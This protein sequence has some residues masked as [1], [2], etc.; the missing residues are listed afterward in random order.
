M[1]EHAFLPPS[2]AHCWVPCTAWPTMNA[3]YPETEERE[4]AR[5]GVAV[6]WASLI[7]WGTVKEGDV[8]PN[9]VVLTDE[10]LETVDIAI[11][12][13][14]PFKDE[15]DAGKRT[16]FVEDTVASG[17]IHHRNWGTPDLWTVADGVLD[18]FD[19]KYGHEFVEVVDNWQLTNYAALILGGGV[20]ADRVNFHVIQPRA[21]S[22]LGP[23][24]RFSYTV[25]ELQPRFK[26]LRDAAREAM[27]TE[28]KA[29]PGPHCKHCNGRHA[30]KAL[31]AA[32]MSAIE[33]AS[34]VLPLELPPQAL[35]IELRMLKQAQTLLDARITGL[36]QQALSLMRTGQRVPHFMIEQSPG[37]EVWTRPIEEVKLLGDLFGVPLQKP[38]LITPNQARK[39]GIRPEVIDAYVDRPKT[40]IKIV[41]ATDEKARRVFG[42]GE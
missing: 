16:L 25:S 15:A 19:L 20:R 39:A 13:F 6:H 17:A 42:R 31:E 24:R 41:P 36:E 27:S 12:V 26:R 21:Y 34:D 29:V 8:A 28:A 3:A 11:D 4:D 23:V 10:M 37:R 32:A 9:G 22:P 2:S 38:A 5:E 35:G 1:S 7:M 18:L 33:Q 30:C 14:R 40:T